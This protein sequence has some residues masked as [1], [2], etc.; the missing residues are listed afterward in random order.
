ME[1]EEL[2]ILWP[3]P[4]EVYESEE[5]TIS[6]QLSDKIGVVIKK[7]YYKR[8]TDEFIVERDAKWLIKGLDPTEEETEAGFKLI[9]EYLSSL[10]RSYTESLEAELAEKKD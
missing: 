2:L 1:N 7:V 4:G 3:V 10:I 8:D 5:P 9:E 6:V